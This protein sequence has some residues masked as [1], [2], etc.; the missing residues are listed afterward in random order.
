MG[1]ILSVIA[2]SHPT[3][4][5]SAANTSEVPDDPIR[6]RPTRTHHQR[7][8]TVAAAVDCF[9]LCLLC[10]WRCAYGGGALATTGYVSLRDLAHSRSSQYSNE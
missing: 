10:V 4:H 3:T 8:T 6:D 1:R 7:V 9:V 2:S 5:Y